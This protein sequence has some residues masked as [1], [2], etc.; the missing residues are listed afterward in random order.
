MVTPLKKHHGQHGGL[1]AL[2]LLAA[3]SI[4][5]WSTHPREPAPPAQSDPGEHR[6]G[7][8]A[9]VVQHAPAIRVEPIEVVTASVTAKAPRTHATVTGVTTFDERR[10]TRLHAPVHGWLQKTRESSLGRRVRQGETLAVIYS[11][12]VYLATVELVDQ[13]KTFRSQELLDAQRYRLLRWGMPRA[14]V[15]Q[16]E[17]T[18]T[19]QAT[20]PLVARGPGTVIAEQG[21]RGQLVEPSG[22]ELFTITDPA[23]AWVYVDVDQDDASRVRVGSKV[24]MKVDGIARRLPATVA[25]VYR[26]VED[27]TRKV[28]L[29][30][31]SPRAHVKAGARVTATLALDGMRPD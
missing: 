7:P 14:M 4:V 13:V 5:V 15:E 16:I 31:Y 2:G 28:R 8:A 10:T 17:R 1:L 19:P 24:T 29:D 18:R 27:G 26:R 23:F 20:L 3:S 25:Y 30:V 11:A 12:E 22:F 21:A 9:A 6:A